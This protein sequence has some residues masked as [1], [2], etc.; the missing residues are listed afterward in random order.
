MPEYVPEFHRFFDRSIQCIVIEA[1]PMFIY[2]YEA[3]PI[4]I[5]ISIVFFIIFF[6]TVKLFPISAI[7]VTLFPSPSFSGTP[8]SSPSHSVKLFLSLSYSVTLS[9]RYPMPPRIDIEPHKAEI[10]DLIAQK[11]THKAIRTILHQN[12][13]IIISRTALKDHLRQ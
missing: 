1:I 11:T 7:A 2:H 6:I 8:F 9:D 12:Y 5:I 4:T 3:I 13:N 10:L